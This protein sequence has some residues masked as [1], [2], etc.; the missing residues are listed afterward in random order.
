MPSHATVSVAHPR[1]L[2]AVTPSVA[3]AVAI[4]RAATVAATWGEF[5]ELLPVTVRVRL[6]QVLYSV[7]GFCEPGDDW[8]DD[9][10]RVCWERADAEFAPDMLDGLTGRL[11][12]DA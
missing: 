11:L 7:Y 4:T 8:W 2:A 5:L 1:P 12:A 6:V 10:L 3:A 9:D